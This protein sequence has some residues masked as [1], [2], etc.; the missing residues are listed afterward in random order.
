MAYLHCHNCNWGQDDF[1]SKDGWR[2]EKSMEGSWDDVFR[3]KI[4]MDHY[5]FK[6]Y[7]LEDKMHED[8]G[9]FWI[10]GQDLVAWNLRRLANNVES[11][12][13]RTYEE[14]KEVHKDFVCPECGSTDLDID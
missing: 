11:M 12:V 13:I 1:W 3:D 8:E 2:P 6:D 14:W 7:G 5:F 9:G 10:R 4:Y